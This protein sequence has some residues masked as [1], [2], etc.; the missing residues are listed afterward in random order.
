[1]IAILGFRRQRHP[2]TQ[3]ANLLVEARAEHSGSGAV[4]LAAA[5]ENRRP[6][7]AVTGR[8]AAFLTAEL[9]AGASNIAALTGRTR[10]GATV[11]QLP[12]DDAVKDVGAGLHGENL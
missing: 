4:G 2:E 8:A 9:L 5:D 6:A 10:R 3:L 1:E 12:G 7:V 11:D